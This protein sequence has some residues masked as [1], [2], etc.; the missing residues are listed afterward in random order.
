MQKPKAMID[1]DKLF[2]KLEEALKKETA[3]SLRKWV[4]KKN[5]QRFIEQN[6]EGAKTTVSKS[7]VIT[8]DSKT[9]LL[10]DIEVT[11][12]TSIDSNKFNSAA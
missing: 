3:A 12:C 11:T 8:Y 7:M 1:H 6:F 5:F 2:S 9:S 10:S 4:Y